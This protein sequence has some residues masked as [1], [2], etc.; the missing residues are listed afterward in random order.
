MADGT[1]AVRGV[2]L[3]ELFPEAE[4]IGAED[5]RVTRCSADSRHCRPGDLFV[6]LPGTHHDG[7]EFVADAVNAGAAGLLVDRPAPGCHVP[8]CLVTETRPAFGRL[9]Q[10]LVGDPSRRL[11]VIGIT[12]TNGKTT[13]SYLVASVLAAAGYRPGVM[14]TLGYSDGEELIPARWTT[15]PANVLASWLARIEA[16][17]CSHAVL[18]VSSHALCQSR[19]AG[20]QLD[21]ACMTNVRHDH[22]DYHRTSAAYYRAKARLF[23]HLAPEGFAVLNADEEACQRYLTRLDG[24]VLTVGLE[25][26]AEV[27]ATPIEQFRSEQTFLLHVGSDTLPVRTRLIGRHN[28]AN[29]LI[30]A[31]VGLAYG[32]E[33]E[34]IVRGLEAVEQLPGRLERLECGQSFGVF[35]DYAHTPD[36]LAGVLESLRSVTPGRLI[37]VFGA[38]GNRDRLKRPRMGR[39]VELGADLAVITT[40]NPRDEEPRRIAAEIL[41]GF[42]HRHAVETII[43]RG[44]AIRWALS[45]AQAGDC[46][47]IAGKGHE[48][49]QVIGDEVLSFD[50]REVACQWLYDSA[51]SYPLY[52]ASA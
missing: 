9:C 27:W 34:V 26:P 32:I 36:A 29:C 46:V 19:V 50:D 1:R 10:A 39:A 6:A 48:D 4:F 44:E 45:Q 35:V 17:G 3:R 13:T 28:I 16:A 2:S 51:R 43:D 25:A 33:P 49:Y 8:A 15:P 18:E 7:H 52:R 21:V 12:G 23:D 14:G 11:K 24:P 30:A 38:G 31:G 42:K 40:D 47:L 20:V 22:L 5:I 41:R 37:C